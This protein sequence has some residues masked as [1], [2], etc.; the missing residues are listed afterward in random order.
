[1]GAPTL[2]GV[3]AVARA[4][5]QRPHDAILDPTGSVTLPDG[6]AG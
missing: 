4:G 1:M 3:L 6:E 2:A 5:R